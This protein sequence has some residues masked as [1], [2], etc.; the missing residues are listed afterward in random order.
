MTDPEKWATEADSATLIAGPR[1][2]RLPSRIA[3]LVRLP[4]PQ[5]AVVLERLLSPALRHLDFLNAYAVEAVHVRY[6]QLVIY[7]DMEIK[8]QTLSEVAFLKLGE[9]PR[10]VSRTRRQEL[11]ECANYSRNAPHGDLPQLPPSGPGE[12]EHG[13]SRRRQ[14]I[15]QRAGHGSRG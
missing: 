9:G 15:Q 14:R 11:H 3:S 1:P 5:F 12:D 8:G 7:S 4:I 10:R 2:S 13:H 6:A